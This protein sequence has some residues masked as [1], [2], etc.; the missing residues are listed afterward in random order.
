ML[1]GGG[2][3]SVSTLTGMLH[4]GELE[5]GRG[6]PG[7]RAGTPETFGAETNQRRISRRRSS[8]SPD[9]EICP[10]GTRQVCVGGVKGRSNGNQRPLGPNSASEAR[11][12]ELEM[13]LKGLWFNSA[14]GRGKPAQSPDGPAASFCSRVHHLFMFS[15]VC[16]C[17]CCVVP[18]D[19][20]AA[21]V[22]LRQ[23]VDG[24]DG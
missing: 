22:A 10:E 3:T 17:V 11:F 21:V 18:C 1:Q 9:A 7:G 5:G 19:P 24:V 8:M 14:V 13:K 23:R 2:A 4:R 20:M 15:C 12:S 16:V 6:G